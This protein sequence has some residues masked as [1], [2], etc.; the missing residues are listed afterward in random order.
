MVKRI[1]FLLTLMFAVTLVIA[2][3]AA[4]QSAPLPPGDLLT[5][6]LAPDARPLVSYRALRRMT[7]STRGGKMSATLDVWT[8]LDPVN[9]F[10]YQIVSEEGS[11]L[12]R[13]RVL[14]EALETE[15][16]A[17]N[18]TDDKDDAA[19]TRANYEFLAMTQ[20]TSDLVRIGVRPLKKHV[21]RVDGAVYVEPV[22]ADLR[23]VEG[24]LSKRP[25]FWTRRVTVEREYQRIGGVHVP[26]SM[27]STADVLLVGA[28]TFSM[29]YE[30]AEINGVAVQ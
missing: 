7:A 29:T 13:T 10:S 20:A 26:V 30:Y 22:S 17:Q 1:A 28:S 18:S 6:F 16:K 27:H 8:T 5:R 25:S 23:R 14:K 3:P 15:R 9:G 4:A 2:D 24:E 12:I 19:L 11:G 21:M